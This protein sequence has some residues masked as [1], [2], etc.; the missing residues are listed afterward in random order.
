MDVGFKNRFGMMGAMGI[1]SV[2]GGG[3]K[4]VGDILGNRRRMRCAG[5][6][7]ENGKQIEFQGINQVGM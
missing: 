6:R 3:N 5:R 1:G 2:E 4:I 7:Q